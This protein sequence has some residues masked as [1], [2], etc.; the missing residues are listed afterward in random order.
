MLGAARSGKTRLARELRN[1]L[2][3][4]GRPC[5]VDDDPPLEAVLAAPRPDAILLCGLDLASFGPVYSRQDSVLRA[6]LASALAEYRIVYGSGEA[7]SRN[8]LAALGFATPDALRLAAAR[9]WRC[10]ECS[11]PHCERRLFHG[12]LHPSH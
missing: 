8:A 11:D 12:L 4:D 2:A 6:Q 1:L 7:R 3:H 10:E 5:Q 9:P